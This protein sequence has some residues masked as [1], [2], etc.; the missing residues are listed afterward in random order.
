MA[1]PG[2]LVGWRNIVD[3]DLVDTRDHPFRAPRIWN[4]ACAPI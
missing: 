3:V 4:L 2:Q 1:T